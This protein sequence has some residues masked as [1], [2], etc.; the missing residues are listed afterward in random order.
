MNLEVV[1]KRPVSQHFK[2]SVVV[3]IFSNIIQII[4]L[5]TSTYTLLCIYHS[6]PLRHITV[7]VNSSKEKWLE[8]LPKITKEFNIVNQ[9]KQ[10]IIRHTWFI[11]ALANNNVGSSFGIVDDEWI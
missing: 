8:L 1:S 6:N 9:V 10:I 5:S 11:P 4:M 7:W 2:E 3:Y